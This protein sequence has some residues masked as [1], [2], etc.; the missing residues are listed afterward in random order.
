M[1]IR[2]RVRG[3]IDTRYVKRGRMQEGTKIHKRVQKGYSGEDLAEVA[4]KYEW[5]KADILLS[6]GGRIDGVLSY[7][8]EPVIEEIKSTY[9]SLDKI[10]EPVEVHLAQA[11][12]YAFVYG[13]QR[14]LTQ[15]SLRVTYYNIPALSLIHI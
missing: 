5:E 12:V 15:I 14:D 13:K 9:L 1:C 11:R 8:S 4:V 7:E 6:I 2:D 3:D 10:E